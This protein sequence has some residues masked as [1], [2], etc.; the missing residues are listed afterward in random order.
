[1]VSLIFTALGINAQYVM[2]LIDAPQQHLGVQPFPWGPNFT[3][4]GEL[5]L[6]KLASAGTFKMFSNKKWI[7]S[8]VCQI[9]LGTTYQNGGI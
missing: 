5:M 8:H 9:F 7:T 6:Q 1:V 2:Y 3:P 4:G